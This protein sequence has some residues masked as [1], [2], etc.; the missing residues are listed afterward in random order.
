MSA[1]DAQ[2]LTQAFFLLALRELYLS[3]FLSDGQ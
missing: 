3:G 1:H 2:D